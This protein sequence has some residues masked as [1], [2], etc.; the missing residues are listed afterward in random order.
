MGTLGSL[1]G[2]PGWILGIVAL[3]QALKAA[4][5]SGSWVSLDDLWASLGGPWVSLGNLWA[6]GKAW[7]A[8][9]QA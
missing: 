6:F 4:S 7:K 8:F 1:L 3:R 9:G 2:K 5:L